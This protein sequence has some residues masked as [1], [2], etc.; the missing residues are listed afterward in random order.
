MSCSTSSMNLTP[1][2]ASFLKRQKEAA[3]SEYN[4][5]VTELA[6]G[7]S[8]HKVYKQDA[9]EAKQIATRY[10][11]TAKKNAATES[12][13]SGQLANMR[14]LFQSG[15]EVGE[16][17]SDP[18]Y[19]ASYGAEKFVNWFNTLALSSNLTSVTT[20]PLYTYNGVASSL[21]TTSLLPTGSDTRVS[22]VA[23]LE[24]VSGAG[25]FNT[26][27]DV[28]TANINADANI[29]APTLISVT[30]TLTEAIRGAIASAESSRHTLEMNAKS[31][32]ILGDAQDA[33][34]QVLLAID[35]PQRCIDRDEA[36]VQ[37]KSITS[38]LY[39]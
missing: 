24:A 13:V 27:A 12:E 9:T 22:G 3:I 1:E 23:A 19:A 25:V 21:I 36:S 20:S 35:A 8:Q 15:L 38:A 14:L 2:S 10:E 30:S 39:C 32:Q 17:L 37:I 26:S 11:S 33:K 5:A 34:S 29:T 7:R 31:T 18:D 6:T 28:T 4:R 16:M